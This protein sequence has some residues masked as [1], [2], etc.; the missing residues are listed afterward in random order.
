MPA[1]KSKRP[2][3]PLQPMRQSLVTEHDE[4]EDHGDEEMIPDGDGE[5]ESPNL[6]EVCRPKLKSL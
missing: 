6:E 2:Q 5:A 4:P 3:T 1:S